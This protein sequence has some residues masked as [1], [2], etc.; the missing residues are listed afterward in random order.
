[1][2][3]SKEALTMENVTCSLSE[4]DLAEMRKNFKIDPSL[5]IILPTSNQT[6]KTP[7]EGFVG[8]YHQFLKAGLR[9]PVFD[10]LKT[11]LSH[12]NLHIAQLGPNSFRKIISFVMLS[13]ALGVPPSLTV[14]RHFFVTLNT[15]DWVSF[16]RRQGIDDICDGIPSSIKK[17]KPE[18]IFVDAKQFSPGMAFA[19]H[20]NRAVDHPPELT[21]AQQCLIDQMVA[22]P[23][24]WSDPDEL[25]LGMAGLSTY[26]TGL[27]KQPIFMVGGKVVTLL[28]RL[29]RR[30]FTGPTEVRE[31]PI[32]D[33]LGPSVLDTAL[34]EESSMD[35]AS[36]TEGAG[37]CTS[38]ATRG[39]R[40]VSKSDRASGRPPSHPGR[41]IKEVFVLKKRGAGAAG[42]GSSSPESEKS[43]AASDESKDVSH[44]KRRR[45]VRGGRHAGKGASD[46][47][48]L[49]TP[50]LFPHVVDKKDV[51]QP[52]LYECPVSADAS[53]GETSSASHALPLGNIIF[54]PS[55]L[56]STASLTRTVDL[57]LPRV[58]ESSAVP[59][60]SSVP[61]P[62][63]KPVG[64][65]ASGFAFRRDLCGAGFGFAD[66][67][68]VGVS[69]P[70]PI[71]TT[72]KQSD[73][74]LDPPVAGKG[75]AEEPEPILSIP[76]VT[77]SPEATVS[78]G[79]PDSPSSLKVLPADDSPTVPTLVSLVAALP[80][81]HRPYVASS[82]GRV[83]GLGD[84]SEEEGLDRARS[85]VLEGMHWVNG[86][87]LRQRTR[88]STLAAQQAE[89]D[90]MKKSIDHAHAD[91]RT[92]VEGK[93]K[94]VSELQQ[95]ELRNQ[96]LVMEIDG[97][98]EK[99]K[100]SLDAH[101][102]VEKQLEDA[103]RHREVD[104]R[105][106]EEVGQ[107][108][109]SLKLLFLEKVAG[110]EILC[111]Q[112]DV[113]LTRQEAEITEQKAKLLSLE[114]QVKTLSVEC[115]ATKQAGLFHQQM[116]EQHAED[117]SWLLK[118]GV[119]SSVRAILNSEEFGSLNAACQTA[120]IQVGLTQ[121]CL[122]M[123][124]K[125]P[126]LEN[127]A[128]LYSYPHSQE[129]MMDRFVQMTNHEYQ[130]LGMLRGSAVG[131]EY[132]KKY[133]D[134]GENEEVNAT[135]EG[136]TEAGD[137]EFVR[138]DSV[139]TAHLNAEDHT[140]GKTS[141]GRGDGDG[142]TSDEI[143]DSEL[144]KVSSEAGV[145]DARGEAK[146]SND[147]SAGGVEG[148]NKP[149]GVGES[150]PSMEVLD[151]SA[152]GICGGY[153]CSKFLVAASHLG[154]PAAWRRAESLRF[155][156]SKSRLCRRSVAFVSGVR[157]V[158]LVVRIA[159]STGIMASEPYTRLNGVSCVEVRTV[160]R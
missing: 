34:E 39:G 98:K 105:K 94:L 137:S 144:V 106:L 112:K 122:E 19:D 71:V 138:V 141:E 145:G 83:P 9:F 109:E 22:H 115:S 49:S 2:D 156:S 27:G 69:S 76:S 100:E 38:D 46:S 80:A 149:E 147:Q 121:A 102:A 86:V 59:E 128:L 40:R 37:E 155:S 29:Q 92:M 146:G 108:F 15:G 148:E 96:E 18:F 70:D 134:D 68:S 103:L 33:F 119:A 159:N 152:D 57:P 90:R 104:L 52:L 25:M 127:E 28:D 97:I 16:T 91:Y 51:S 23:V 113:V 107:Q 17:W 143:E 110:L 129:E 101:Q 117:L 67:A 84:M 140:E 81:F 77:T 54:S 120:A 1:M 64:V 48:P 60:V 43:V 130:L 87:M 154:W 32:T 61:P 151:K 41:T 99:Q 157:P 153:S 8:I 44:S 47:E 123:K 35:S 31:G 132:L 36:Q 142:I 73:S 118:Y 63:C 14:F 88:A 21:S 66:F 20:K 135:A 58:S 75:S 78:P 72:E 3:T 79:V 13:R 24:K 111:N 114:D 82:V 26:W 65:K 10:F 150:G 124:A 74:S 6:I 116:S 5:Q 85:L 136:T 89:C 11:V 133:L 4:D 53:L 12:Y 160:V 158:V 126:V 56:P 95:M 30:K 131:V 7:P 50:P 62:L 45:L 42:G 55:R 139:D 93:L 125:Y